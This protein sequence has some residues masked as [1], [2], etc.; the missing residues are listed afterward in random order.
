MQL[1]AHVPPSFTHV[2]PSLKRLL[3]LAFLVLV[4]T[5]GGDDSPTA[6]EDPP[7]LTYS[8]TALTFS[9]QEGGAS[10]A[11][12]TITV[13]N[14]GGGTLSW[15]A[16]AD[17]PWMTVSPSSGT[18]TG[19]AS[20]ITVT[21][22][23]TGLSA[24]AYSGAV[25]ITGGSAPVSAVVALTVDDPDLIP[26]LTRSPSAM[27]FSAA[28][29]GNSPA[30]QSLSVSNSGDGTLSWGVSSDQTWL[31]LSPTSGT[32]TGESDAVTV[33][34]NV[35]GLTAGSYDATITVTGQPP[36]TSTPQT[37][38]VTF[39]VVEPATV[40]STSVATGDSLV[41]IVADF[42]AT[43]SRNMNASTINTSTVTLSGPGGPVS[44]TVGYDAG[45]R[46][47]TFSPNDPLTEFRSEYTFTV[48][49]GAE[50]T[51]GAPIE[52]TVTRTFLTEFVSELF[53][54]RLWNDFKGDQ[55]VLDTFSNT[56]ECHHA[57]RSANTSGSFWYFVPQGN[58]RFFIRNTF[59]GD[60][61]QLEGTDGV[62]P[63]R[64]DPVG[65]F[66]GQRWYFEQL[67]E[68]AYRFRTVSF[69]DVKALDNYNDGR[70]PEQAY[71][72]DAGAFSGQFWHFDRAT[73]R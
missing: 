48:T 69:G 66:T 27:T 1:R 35:S 21:V 73:A 4:A 28:Q 65:N 53:T 45:S 67:S 6:T 59:Q 2:P 56:F 39:T 17:Q 44:G 34:A 3:Q 24:G 20:A 41:S 60:A 23:T 61:R 42:D 12:G 47:A 11:P 52:G 31:T 70:D 43:F 5:C 13:M 40:V 49:T 26:E 54:Y 51:L 58:G 16:S 62:G 71:M 63:C 36:A 68:T 29:G 7:V 72:A 8:P 57:D 19:E 18:S 46:T 22:S 37:T 15:T 14:A 38:T 64:L 50:D 9:G 10:P 33:S 30:S 25:T 55:L 32:S